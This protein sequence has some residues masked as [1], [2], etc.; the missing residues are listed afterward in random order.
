MPEP[1]H[2]TAPAPRRS[3][4]RLLLL[5]GGLAGLLIVAALGGVSLFWR[6]AE[7]GGLVF[8]IPD[9]AADLLERPTIDSAIAI[10]TD[11]RFGPGGTARITVRNEDSTM[12]RAGPWLIGPGQTYT[13]SFD[14]PGTY[15]FDCSVD[16]A[17][18]VTVTVTD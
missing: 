9:G 18:S 10:P 7:A 3:R 16:P 11:I 13:A 2:D 17:E 8:V 6:P 14:E 1:R 12:N 15:Q 4:G 5:S